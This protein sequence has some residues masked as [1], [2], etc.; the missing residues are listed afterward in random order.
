MFSYPILRGIRQCK[1]M[2]FRRLFFGWC[3]D[4]DC[5]LPKMAILFETATFPVL[6]SNSRSC[7]NTAL[8]WICKIEAGGSKRR[9]WKAELLRIETARIKDDV[10]NRL[11][12]STKAELY[13]IL[14]LALF[15]WVI[16]L[17][18]LF[19]GMFI[20]VGVYHSILWFV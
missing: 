9:D 13:H 2:G 11:K 17:L 1:C 16:F 5:S 20:F 8:P 14:L 18:S 10:S 4:P 7:C 6:F 19:T 12:P 3:W 15:S